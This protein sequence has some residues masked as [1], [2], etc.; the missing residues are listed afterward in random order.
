MSDSVIF[1]DIHESCG[2]KPIT[3]DRGAK[4]VRFERRCKEC[5]APFVTHTPNKQT[6]SEACAEERSKKCPS[7]KRRKGKGALVVALDAQCCGRRLRNCDFEY[8]RLGRSL[9]RCPLCRSVQ[10]V[11]RKDVA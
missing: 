10:T 6:C 11:R 2:R 5:G 1:D 7:K 8:D 4:H 3:L 9:V